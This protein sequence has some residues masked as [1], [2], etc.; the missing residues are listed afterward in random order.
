MRFAGKTDARMLALAILLMLCGGV[1]FSQSVSDSGTPPSLPYAPPPPLTY[2]GDDDGVSSEEFERFITTRK[3][4][5]VP[6]T[7]PPAPSGLVEAPPLIQEA[8]PFSQENRSASPTVTAQPFDPLHGPQ[9]LVPSEPPPTYSENAATTDSSAPPMPQQGPWW[10][11]NEY[12][13]SPILVGND[14]GVC[15]VD[16]EQL[17]WQSMQYSPRVQSILIVPKIQ[18][19]EEDMARGDMDPKRFAQSI[20]H[21]TSDPVGNTLTT[22]GPSRLNEEFWEN[23]AGI[24]DRNILGGKSDFSQAFNARDNNSLFF[25]PNNQ[26]D[27]KLSVN[28]TQPLLRGAGKF[29]NTSSIRLAGIKTKNSIANANRELQNHAM[30]IINAYWELTLHRYLLVQARNGQDRLKAI[31]QKLQDREGIDLLPSHISRANAAVSSQQGQIEIARANIKKYEAKLR[32]LVNSPDLQ[33]GICQEIIPL[34]APTVDIPNI[35]LEDELYSAIM[36]RGD[37]QSIQQEIE[38]ATVQQKLAVNELRPTLDLMASSYVRGLRG[39]NDFLRSWSS[40]FD[41]GRPSFTSGLE[42][43]NPV[44]N[45]AAKANVVGRSLELAKLMNDYSNALLTARAD[46]TAAVDLSK[47]TLASALSAIDQTWASKEEVESHMARFYDAF[48]DNPSLSNILND[49]L[50]A[51][52]RLIAAENTWA[53]R[54]IQHMQALAQIQYEAGTLMTI[55]AE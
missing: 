32:Q 41:T 51:E 4:A 13:L 7:V 15:R 20:Y 27:T 24:R 54:Q 48:G 19:T 29:Y 16:L 25:K 9:P 12:S 49:L 39:D 1:S 6:H 38:S 55:S 43:Q 21:N 33:I 36:Y 5:V 18:R 2:E 8:I 37:I 3:P 30:D 17:I 34:T 14:Q 40:Q 28:Y 46:I 22:G 11:W 23:S 45:R 10:G 35:P 52:N 31:K 42:Y 26:A 44:G 53:N 47:G 50:D